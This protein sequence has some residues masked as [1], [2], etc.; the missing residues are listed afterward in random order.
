MGGYGAIKNGL[1][2]HETFG[3]IAG[4]SNALILERVLNM[5]YDAPLVQNRAYFES[6]FGDINE[7]LARDKNPRVL[8]KTLKEK[9]RENKNVHFPKMYIACGTEDHTLVD[10]NR[11]LRDFLIENN[12]DLT[13]V[14]GPGGHDWE[15]WDTYIK[16]VIDWLPLDNDASAGLNSGNVGV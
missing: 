7:A 14:E 10:A 9:M 2:Y 1:T 6:C 12:V 16:K 13:Y 4:L 11:D 8:V 15:F 3:C 5:T